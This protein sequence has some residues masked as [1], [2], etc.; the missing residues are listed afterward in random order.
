MKLVAKIIIIGS[1]CGALIIFSAFWRHDPKQA[2]LENDSATLFLRPIESQK[3]FYDPVNFKQAI[4]S[5]EKVHSQNDIQAIVVPQHLVASSL[6]AQAIKQAAGRDIE[7]VFIIG[8]NHFNVGTADIASA[9]A[10]WKTDLGDVE[11]DTGLV[12]KFITDLNL[13]NG[14]EIFINEHAVGALVPFVKYYLPQ[15]KIVPIVFRSYSNLGDV[16]QVVN[17][18][19]DNLPKKSL[20][21]YSIDFSHYLPREQADHMDELTRQYITNNDLEQIIKLGDDNLDSPASLATA[22]SLAQKKNWH[23]EIVA[24]KNSDDFTKVKSTQTTSYFLINFSD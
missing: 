7:T 14:P 20:V 22:L 17:W 19:A 16:D 15:A 10:V 2:N 6:M 18:L 23:L 5:A 3:M 8:P 12:S 11:S 1:I 21:I 9:Q 13:L 4:L 24:N